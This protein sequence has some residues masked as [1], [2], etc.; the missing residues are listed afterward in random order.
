MHHEWQD[1]DRSA[2]KLCTEN[3]ADL[4]NIKTKF[5]WLAETEH[6]YSDYFTVAE[7][8]VRA[9]IK[10]INGHGKENERKCRI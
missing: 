2:V 8:T 7:S 1:I 6:N 10:T 4:A 5:N 3:I 9:K